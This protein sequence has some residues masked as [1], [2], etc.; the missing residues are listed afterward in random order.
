MTD[1][2]KDF[3]ILVDT[4]EKDPGIIFPFLTKIQIRNWWGTGRPGRFVKASPN[5][6]DLDLSLGESYDYELVNIITSITSLTNLEMAFKI[7]PES[8]PPRARARLEGFESEE[9][10]FSGFDLFSTP[11]SSSSNE[12]LKWILSGEVP[13]LTNLNLAN[14]RILNC[15]NNVWNLFNQIIEKNTTLKKLTLSDSCCPVSVTKS[16][17]ESLKKNTTLEYVNLIECASSAE[18][19]EMAAN[20]SQERNVKILVGKHK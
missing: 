4:L 18:I 8:P 16:L 12:L 5:L 20:I 7:P 1:P 2:G 19:W 11:F 3:G 13:N 15:P 6:V 9:D 10:E 14:Q 17:V